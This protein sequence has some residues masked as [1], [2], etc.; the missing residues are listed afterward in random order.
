MVV[1]S[2]E[3]D[4]VLLQ[5]LIKPRRYWV[6]MAQIWKSLVNGSNILDVVH[7]YLLQV[8]FLINFNIIHNELI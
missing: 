2:D 8:L 5:I 6:V 1:L 3:T 7:F 4:Q